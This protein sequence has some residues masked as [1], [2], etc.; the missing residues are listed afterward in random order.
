QKEIYINHLQRWLEG[1]V[2]SYEAEISSLQGVI[3]DLKEKIRV[4]I[5]GIYFSPKGGCENVIISWIRSANRS[6]HVLIYSFTLDLIAEELIYAYKRGVDVK[7][8]FEKS[9]IS[10]YSEY[11]RLKEAGV[12][13]RNDTNPDFMHNKVMIIDGEIVFTGSYNWSKSA[14]EDNDEN[15][16]IIKSMEIAETYEEK[17]EE[18]WNK[19]V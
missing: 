5:L 12:P 17:F 2:S 19:G 4:E 11:M 6:I 14:E 8:L 9:Q 16:I 13:V 1:N 3:S 18:I 7:V 10:L 15:L